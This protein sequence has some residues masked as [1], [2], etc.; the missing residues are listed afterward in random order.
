MILVILISDATDTSY[1]ND[2]YFFIFPQKT[3]I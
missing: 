1:K 2:T 3:N